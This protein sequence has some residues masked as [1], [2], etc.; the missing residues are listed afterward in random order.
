MKITLEFWSIF[1]LISSFNGIMYCFFI[2]LDKRMQGKANVW[3]ALLLISVSIFIFEFFLIRNNIAYWSNN[4]QLIFI[5]SATAF[6]ISPFLFL[7][8]K[9]IL[10]KSTKPWAVVGHMLLFLITALNFSPVLMSLLER[11]ISNKI[12]STEP[13]INISGLYYM[14]SM[15]IQTFIYLM[16]ITKLLRKET[17]NIK[18]T[19]SSADMV[20]V[21]WLMKIVKSFGYATIVL[22][23]SFLFIFFIRFVESIEFIIVSSIAIVI[24]I[25]GYNYVNMPVLIKKPENNNYKEKKPV[26]NYEK[27][28][29]DALNLKNLI[30]TEKP[31]LKDDLRLAELS[32]I[33]SLPTNYVSELINTYLN[34]NFFDFINSYRIEEIKQKLL[35]PQY[36]HFSILGIAMECGFNN[37]TSFNRVF[38]KLT[39]ETP[40]SYIKRQQL[41]P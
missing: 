37:K 13:F 28:N 24:Y 15:L 6:L 29:K 31:Y 21:F 11:L 3:L 26:S 41:I 32:E 27:M 35:D 1:F 18:K 16:L 36:Q 10:G 20:F 7:F 25:V 12:Y 22:F 34:T 19:Q 2:F 4:K 8:V 33:L 39:G 30:E 5:N 38:K 23:L 9:S 40:T 14:G 17:K